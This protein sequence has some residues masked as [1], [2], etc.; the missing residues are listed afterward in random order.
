MASL[1]WIESTY[2][3]NVLIALRSSHEKLRETSYFFIV[4]VGDIQN[5]V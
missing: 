5:E 1:G 3:Y 4:L 2:R